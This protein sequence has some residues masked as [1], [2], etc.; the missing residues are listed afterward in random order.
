[1]DEI[2]RIVFLSVFL[3]LGIPLFVI[4]LKWYFGWRKSGF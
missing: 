1:M 3:I 4:I 2:I